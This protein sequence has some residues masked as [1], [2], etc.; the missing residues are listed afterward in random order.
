M[1]KSMLKDVYKK[2]QHY[3]T[4]FFLPSMKLIEKKRIGSKIIK[5]HSKP[6]TPYSRIMQSE[7]VEEEVKRRLTQ[8]FKRINPFSLQKRLKKKIGAIMKMTVK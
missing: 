2:E 1:M 8:E 4:N 7:Y 5:R 3:M 6:E